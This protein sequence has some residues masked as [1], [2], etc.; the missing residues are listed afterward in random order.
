MSDESSATVR[1]GALRERIWR[2]NHVPRRASHPWVF[3]GDSTCGRSDF[4]SFPPCRAHGAS[5]LRRLDLWE[6]SRAK[7][8][9]FLNHACAER[10]DSWLTIISMLLECQRVEVSQLGEELTE[11]VLRMQRF[12]HEL[13][14]TVVIE[15]EVAACSELIADLTRDIG[16]RHEAALDILPELAELSAPLSTWRSDMAAAQLRLDRIRKEI[17]LETSAAQ[18]AEATEMTRVWM[19]VFALEPHAHFACPVCRPRES[20]LWP[21]QR[22][23][24]P[25]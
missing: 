4:V 1:R 10:A 7:Y 3:A 16:E 6:A 5:L 2:L 25:R 19:E 14:Q 11:K 18:R 17:A 24:H 9:Q 20:P 13:P 8:Q 15:D 23:P 21:A 12:L 22:L